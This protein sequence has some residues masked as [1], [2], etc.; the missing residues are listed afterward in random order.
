MV[1]ALATNLKLFPGLVALWW[2]GRRDWRSVARF[3]FWMLALGVGQVVLEPGGSAAFPATLSFDQVGQV[4]NLSPY[5]LSPA[6]WVV[7]VPVGIAGALVLARTSYGWPAAVA[8]S[9]LVTPRLTTYLLMNFL[10][11]VRTPPF[12]SARTREEIREAAPEGN[13][14]ASAHT[15]GDV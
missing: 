10:A 7:L 9:T 8:V 11:A 14:G 1:G 5:A 6:L 13:P 15:L 3:G 12:G 4:V 2:I